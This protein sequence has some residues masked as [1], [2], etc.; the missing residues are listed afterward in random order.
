MQLLIIRPLSFFFVLV[1][2]VWINVLKWRYGSYENIPVNQLPISPLDYEQVREKLKRMFEMANDY[3]YLCNVL[4]VSS[5]DSEFG[6]A[7]TR[8]FSSSSVDVKEYEG[9][10]RII[11]SPHRRKSILNT[12]V[13]L[14]DVSSRKVDYVYRNSEQFRIWINV[15]S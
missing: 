14:G 11:A 13:N 10:H 1:A 3:D 4:N 2:T 5:T 12:M 9:L 8:L 15:R 6:K 7:L